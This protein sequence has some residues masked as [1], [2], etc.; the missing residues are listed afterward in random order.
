MDKALDVSYVGE[1][2]VYCL[3]FIVYCLDVWIQAR[4]VGC[5]GEIFL[6]MPR[7]MVT[8]GE[9]CT[10]TSHPRLFNAPN[11][12]SGAQDADANRMATGSRSAQILRRA[13]PIAPTFNPKTRNSGLA[14]RLSQCDVL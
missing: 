14:P 12:P 6:F 9:C 10:A 2:L 3:L 1:L 13:A 7:R 4:R 11:K 8:E 5:P